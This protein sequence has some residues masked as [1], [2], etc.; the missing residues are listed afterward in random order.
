MFP[1]QIRT[2]ESDVLVVGGGLS[3]RD[4][5]VVGGGL[6]GLMA[7]LEA[8]KTAP[9]VTVLCKRKSGTSGN[10]LVSGAGFATFVSGRDDSLDQYFSDTM[11]SGKGINER[12]L[13]EILVN[14]STEAISTLE[15][16]GVKFNRI[17]GQL[18]YKHAPGHSHS[19]S[20]YCDFGP[21]EQTIRGLSILKP[22]LDQV[23]KA[24]VRLVNHVAVVKL[25]KKD[26]TV[27][28]AVGLDL[29]KEELIYFSA[30][31]IILAAGGAGRLFSR[32]NNTAEMTGDSFSLALDA[33]A[34][35]RDME[36]VQFYPTMLNHP[37]K[38]PLSN[39]LF[40]DGAVLRNAM[41]ERFMSK[42]A[43]EEAD[44]ATRDKM[45]QAIFAE[46][47]AGKGI[48]D[49]VYLDCT[50]ISPKAFE[51][52]H[53]RLKEYLYQHGVDMQKSWM[54]VSPAVHF[55]MGGVKINEHCETT[56]EGLYA[57]GEC[58]G[59][60]HGANRLATNAL[61]EAAVFGRIAGK[62][63]ASFAAKV[64]NIKVPL[65]KFSLPDADP[66]KATFSEIRDFLC[67]TMW[68]H[69]SIIRSQKSL[70]QALENI[71]HSKENLNYTGCVSFRDISKYFELQGMC[72]VAE[73]I[74]RAALFREESRG[75]HFREDFSGEDPGWLGS[76]EINKQNNNLE[77][78]FEA[79]S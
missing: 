32:N 78:H 48:A 15:R 67:R 17:N 45:C 57:S 25:V 60:V 37:V 41:G 49:Q 69:A 7:A 31:S 71:Q 35:L 44:M 43:P 11:R 39:T 63:A 73:V 47:R 26:G 64:S 76:V 59:G 8:V 75:S 23:S 30:K 19:R 53:Y 77:F 14:E 74:V 56:L 20:L 24:G 3:G 50:G 9:R 13:V 58:A 36:F 72:N 29:T 22:L 21:R 4:V 52:K 16:Y 40:G 1:F 65:P 12:A 18:I 61:T 66:G 6:S 70:L 34:A 79:S 54:L 68:E 10:T 46:L 33:G 55:F 42:Y 5:L 28:G 38:I 2:E 27:I 62:S 51:T